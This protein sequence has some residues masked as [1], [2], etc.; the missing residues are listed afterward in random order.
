MDEFK[1]QIVLENLEEGKSM[2]LIAL[3][4]GIQ[5]NVFYNWKTQILIGKGNFG[6]SLHVEQTL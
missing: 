3:A 5:L 6:K 2:N 4:Y 1:S